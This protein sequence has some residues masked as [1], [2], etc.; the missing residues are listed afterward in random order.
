ML[1]PKNLGTFFARNHD[2][3]IPIGIEVGSDDVKSD[4]CSLGR[5]I[6]TE[7]LELFIPSVVHDDRNIVRTRVPTVVPVNTLTGNQFV[8][9]V[10][11]QICEVKRVS[12]TERI[13]DLDFIIKKVAIIIEALPQ[14]C[15][16][17][18]IMTIAPNQIVLAIA[19]DIT[20]QY[21]TRQ[22]LGPAWVKLPWT[23]IRITLGPFVPTCT[24]YNI[25]SPI[26]I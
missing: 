8:H 9:A 19:V 10:A 17:S 21:R 6:L 22:T 14:P 5:D 24:D 23:G 13:V 16:D 18:V 1:I 11:V 15:E 12:L 20:D 26:V 4:T 25:A 2:L 7:I 3:E